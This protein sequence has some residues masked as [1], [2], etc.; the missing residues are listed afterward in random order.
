MIFMPWYSPITFNDL[1]P[2]TIKPAFSLTAHATN[3]LSEGSSFTTHIRGVLAVNRILTPC[4]NRASNSVN[5]SSAPSPIRCK[6]STYSSRI[7]LERQRTISPHFQRSMTWRGRQPRKEDTNTF[8]SMKTF[9]LFLESCP[10]YGG[11]VCD[12]DLGW[13]LM[14]KQSLINR[15]RLTPE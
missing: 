9:P 5:S 1:S 11:L 8:V 3:L 4:L 6:T 10:F 12:Q 14:P 7:S 13:Q 15:F 2:V